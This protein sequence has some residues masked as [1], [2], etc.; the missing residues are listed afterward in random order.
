MKSNLLCI[1]PARGGSTRIPQKNITNLG[2]IPLLKYTWDAAKE[3]GIAEHT[4][5]STDDES[6]VQYAKQLNASFI[7]RPEEFSNSTASTESALIHA[8]DFLNHDYEWVMTLPPTS[9]FRG[10]EIIQFVLNELPKLKKDCIMSVSANYG[11]FW[12]GDPKKEFKR[13][14]PDAPRRQQDR[15]PLWE[16]NSAIYCTKVD[17]LRKT[18]SI[19]GESVQ[20]FEISQKE[21]WDINTPFDL[22]VAEAMLK[23]QN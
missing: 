6:I 21:A 5:I 16:E 20:G 8:I 12:L 4:Y 10:S 11:D 2:G 14:V 22:I 13:R 7:P 9:P 19:L 17:A 15:E 3:A 1:I 23:S 18:G